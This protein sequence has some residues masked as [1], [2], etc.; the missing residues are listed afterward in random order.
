MVDFSKTQEMDLYIPKECHRLSCVGTI[1][2]DVD[3]LQLAT[4]ISTIHDSFCSQYFL[5]TMPQSV[6]R[7][8]EQEKTQTNNDL[9]NYGN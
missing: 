4:L 5:T 8:R 1:W 2:C 3:S 7:E 9:I 6:N